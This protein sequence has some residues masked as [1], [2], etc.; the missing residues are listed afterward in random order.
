MVKPIYPCLWFDGTAK[1]AAEFY[2]SIFEQ[3]SIRSDT[4]MV[5]DFQ[6]NGFRLMGLNGGP[7][8]TINPS[9]SLFVNCETIEET[10]AIYNKL[11]EG[12][13]AM[14]P[15]DEYPWSPRY[16]WL[17]DKFGL[18]WQVSL[19]NNPGD[20]RKIRPSFLFTGVRFGRAEESIDFYRT[21]FNNSTKD[22]V[23]NFPEGDD[24]EG[25]LMYGEFSLNGYE[26]IAMD[27]PGEHKFDFNEAVSFVIEC[28]TQDEIDYYWNRLTQEGEES[29]CG[30]LKD[31]FG[32]S[33]QVIPSALNE[34]M[35]DPEKAQR[36]FTAFQSM[37][38][39]DLAKL[40]AA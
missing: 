39:L 20:P 25:K 5:V 31:R 21:I 37:K 14:M 19:V 38:K 4:P 8:F 3:S 32:V 1:A 36:I 6:L 12:G 15:I 33:W 40:I 24:F 28:D 22:F 29:M 18:T 23:V 11:I 30:W 10:N 7:M 35:Q 2:C 34:L 9:I 27:G 13:S 17:K 26:M 16:G